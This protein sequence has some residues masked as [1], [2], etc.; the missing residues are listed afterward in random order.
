MG[1]C[2][3]YG[4]LVYDVIIDLFC[5]IFGI[6]YNQQ[7]CM[8]VWL[9]LIYNFYSSRL[10]PNFS[11]G[12]KL[13]HVF[14]NALYIWIICHMAFLTEPNFLNFLSQISAFQQILSDPS[15]K[16]TVISSQT[17]QFL[18]K[19]LTDP[20]VFSNTAD[21]MLRRMH[22]KQKYKMQSTIWN[23]YQ[24]S[25]L[26]PNPSIFHPLWVGQSSIGWASRIYTGPLGH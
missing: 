2:L 10:K 24:K 6:F 18:S 3:K 21:L 15:M 26:D 11:K 14:W 19:N 8:N 9:N 22:E 16:W 12:K 5:I 7:N 4:D 20:K 13:L 17:K 25:F 1:T 23:K